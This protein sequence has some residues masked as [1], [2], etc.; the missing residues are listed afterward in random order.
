MRVYLDTNVLISALATRGLCADLLEVILADHD[1]LVGETV[2][3]EL[4]RVLSRKMHLAPKAV[5]EL[6][7][8]LRRQGEVVHS[9]RLL[10]L[11]VRDPADRPILAEA[12][13]GRAQLLVTGDR[14]LLVLAARAPIAIRSPREVWE[15]LRS[16][17][18]KRGGAS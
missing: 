1:L 15:L 7:A 6:D 17:E 16:G 2:L 18:T 3:K 13:A 10:R 9:D 14:D 5:T 8:F 12:V 11:K 4:Q